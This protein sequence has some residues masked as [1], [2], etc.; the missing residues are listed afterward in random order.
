LHAV[1][2]AEAEAAVFD[3]EQAR[4]A[5]LEHLQP[6]AL[7]EPEFGKPADGRGFAA[8]FGHLGHFTD[9]QQVQG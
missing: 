6:A 1:G 5:R 4:G 7:A 3:L 9:G 2:P 8:D